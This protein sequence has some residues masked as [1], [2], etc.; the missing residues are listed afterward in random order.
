MYSAN[1]PSLIASK[2][3]NILIITIVVR[4][5]KTSALSVIEYRREQ[6]RHG[7]WP[8]D[9]SYWSYAWPWRGKG[10]ILCVKMKV[11][12]LNTDFAEIYHYADI[13]ECVLDVIEWKHAYW[14]L[15]NRLPVLMK[16]SER[17]QFCHTR[18]Q[19]VHVSPT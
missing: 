11:A 16:I 12:G 14:N 18:R 1:P 15:P 3:L 6:R 5:V 10:V 4:K 19:P 7:A 8:N 17:R 9:S 2:E 13:S